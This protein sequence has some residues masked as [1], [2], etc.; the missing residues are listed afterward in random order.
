MCMDMFA[1]FDVGRS[2]ADAF[3]VFDDVFALGNIRARELVK[4]RHRSRYFHLAKLA[5]VTVA[6]DISGFKGLDRDADIVFAVHQYGI[7]G[8]MLF[9][10]FLNVLGGC[11]ELNLELL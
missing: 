5:A 10:P 2:G 1:D 4:D 7:D 11:P 6:G 9:T 8:H 3:A